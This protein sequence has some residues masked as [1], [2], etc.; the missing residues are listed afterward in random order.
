MRKGEVSL[1]SILHGWCRASFCFFAL[2]FVAWRWNLVRV[3][4][5]SAA[6]AV[7]FCRFWMSFRR[8]GVTKL[9]PECSPDEALITSRQ[10]KRV[11]SEGTT[12][13]RRCSR[14][15]DYRG[16]TTP[17]FSYTTASPLERYAPPPDWASLAAP[18]S[19]ATACCTGTLLPTTTAGH[20]T[21]EFV[22]PPRDGRSKRTLA[23]FFRAEQRID[24]HHT[25][26][27]IRRTMPVRLGFGQSNPIAA[28]IEIEHQT[29]CAGGRQL[30]WSRQSQAAL[31]RSA[32]GA[33]QTRRRWL[34]QPSVQMHPPGEMAFWPAS[35]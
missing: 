32:V 3:S 30:A 13:Y 22:P 15:E 16:R 21:P 27:S 25:L 18:Q 11:A 23:G 1:M 12:V 4:H 19:L 8:T 29:P 34:M 33:G 24:G 10:R 20:A 5:F 7:M 14:I 9:S 6:S 17:Q 28:T 26:R 2:L 35:A 31:A